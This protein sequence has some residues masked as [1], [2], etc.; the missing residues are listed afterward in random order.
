[1]WFKVTADV[2][3]A[4]GDSSS[5]IAP[6]LD[7]VFNRTLMVKIN[8]HTSKAVPLNKQWEGSPLLCGAVGRAVVVYLKQSNNRRG[9]T[10][11]T[12]W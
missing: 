10:A 11:A 2:C 4:P 1:M 12:V 8:D 3:K 6:L 9:H 7:V 5:M